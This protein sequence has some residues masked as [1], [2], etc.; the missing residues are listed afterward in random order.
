MKFWVQDAHG[1]RTACT[2]DDLLEAIIRAETSHVFVEK[3]DEDFSVCENVANLPIGRLGLSNKTCAALLRSRI[4]GTVGDLVIAD[5]ED[6]LSVNGIGEI[7]YEEIRNKMKQK[8][9][10]DMAP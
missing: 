9:D 1:N 4:F 10:L 2:S 6:V 7:R 5:K 8:F 3:A